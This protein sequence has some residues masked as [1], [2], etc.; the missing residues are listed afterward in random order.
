MRRSERSPR[1]AILLKSKVLLEVPEK[2]RRNAASLGEPGRAWLADLPRQITELERRWA[3]KV[4]QP[5][6]DGTEAF[7]AEARTNSGLDVVLKIAIPGIDPTR[8]ELRILRIARGIGYAEL[9]CGDENDNVMLL[10]KL[11]PQLH[12]FHFPEDRQIR[13]I[14]DTLHEAWTHPPPGQSF[15]TGADRAVELSRIIQ[16]HWNSHGKPCSERAFELALSYAERR[17]RM[18]DPAQSVLLHGDAHEW[19]TLRAPASTTGFKFVDPDGAFAERAFDL[20]IP[21][22]EW[23]NIIPEGDL[24]QLGYHRCNLLSAIT[25]VECEPIWEWALIQ[26]VSN[27]LLLQ[28]IGLDDLAAVQFAVADAWAAGG[29]LVRR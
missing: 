9:I 2:V 17:R 26:C 12:E 25:G 11:G 6:R 24:L 27:G 23:G 19:N 20:A 8:Q 29:D 16:S 4:G 10:E 14:C 21:M 5:A 22:R 13:V 18:F 15:V 28:Q 3:I 7:V 1:E